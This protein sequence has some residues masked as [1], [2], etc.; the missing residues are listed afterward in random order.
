MSLN[1]LSPDYN[2]KRYKQREKLYQAMKAGHNDS[3]LFDH[4][5]LS[6][7][8]YNDWDFEKDE[9]FLSSQ[10][11]YE[12]FVKIDADLKRNS[13]YKPD[14]MLEI[15]KM[16]LGDRYKAFHR[17]YKQ[18]YKVNP[19]SKKRYLTKAQKDIEN[20]L[21]KYEM[22]IAIDKWSDREKNGV[23]KA[24]VLLANYYQSTGRF[25][26][27]DTIR[28]TPIIKPKSFTKIAKAWREFHTPKM[29]KA[30]KI[31]EKEANKL[32]QGVIEKIKLNF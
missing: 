22:D 24:V 19:I 18:Q 29:V 16:L 6:F 7:K 4:D 2:P 10:R 14:M 31:P 5:R 23:M 8:Q 28:H 3:F 25:D 30:C 26:L 9:Q 15:V 13:S 1:A 11:I 20:V 17:I 12:E 21:Y 32:L 27:A